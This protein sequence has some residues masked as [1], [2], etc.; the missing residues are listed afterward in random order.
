M[1]AT[2]CTDTP[3]DASLRCTSAQS[4]SVVVYSLI[5]GIIGR[6]VLVELCERGFMCSTFH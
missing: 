5:V 1:V 2:Q 4:K 6:I 3:I